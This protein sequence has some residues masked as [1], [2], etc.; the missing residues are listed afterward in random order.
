MCISTVHMK[1][2]KTKAIA[3]REEGYTYSEILEQINVA[4]STLSL[5]LRDVGLTVRQ[6]QRI[7]EK[8]LKSALRGAEARRQNR[9]ELTEQIFQKSK[10]EIKNLNSRELWLLGI[11]LYWAEGS[12][13]KEIRPGSGVQFTNSDCKMIKI[14]LKWLI[15]VCHIQRDQIYFEIYVHDTHR[16]HLGRVQEH[17]SS[18]TGFP[19]SNFDRIYFKKNKIGTLRKNIGETYFGT[20]KV[21]VKSSSTLNRTIAGWI[22]GVVECSDRI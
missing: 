11:V 17:W 10:S 18:K 4:K 1:I 22:Q 3:L 12:K 2:L 14:F 9:I 8:K 19:I 7:T 13:E 5:W 15:D 6:K 20:L 21:R 16:D